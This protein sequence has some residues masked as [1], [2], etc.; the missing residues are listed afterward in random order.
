MKWEKREW[1]C[2]TER[3]EMRE[4]RKSV[5]VSVSKWDRERVLKHAFRTW[6]NFFTGRQRAIAHTTKKASSKKPVDFF[7]QRFFL[8]TLRQIQDFLKT[9]IANLLSPEQPLVASHLHFSNDGCSKPVSA[10]GCNRASKRTET[11][12]VDRPS[13]PWKSGQKF[14]NLAPK[15]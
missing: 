13:R 7:C 1:V 9:Q 8:Q 12:L 2:E 3:D 6:A 11:G 15:Y 5:R 14:S 4:T 10:S